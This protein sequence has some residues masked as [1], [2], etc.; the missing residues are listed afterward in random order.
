MEEKEVKALLE[1]LAEKNGKAIKEAVKA[2]M[3]AFQ[4]G[5]L[6]K[7]DFEATL[8]EAGFDK[9]TMEKLTTAVEKQGEE[10][11]KSYEKANANPKTVQEI[12]HEK[13]GRD[14][15]T[16]KRRKRRETDHPQ[17]GDH[18]FECNFDHTGTT[19]YRHWTAS[20][21]GDYHVWFVPSCAGEP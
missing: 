12:V 15:R 1:G 5:V 14:R 21:S 2:E 7:A 9:A 8:K 3:E 6:K 18:P 10:M 16:R 13:K 4:A 19:P 11:R 17:N 20:L